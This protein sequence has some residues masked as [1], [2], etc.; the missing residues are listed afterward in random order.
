MVK[1]TRPSRICRERVSVH[2]FTLIELLVVI[3]IIAVLAAMLSPVLDHARNAADLA[4]CRSNL[5]Q[6]GLGL[7]M[8]VQQSG[9]YPGGTTASEIYNAEFLLQPFVAPWP[10]NNY[11]YTGGQTTSYLEPARSVWA[12]PGYNNAHGEFS[13][14]AGSYGYNVTGSCWYAPGPQ[15]GL[16]ARGVPDDTGTG[17]GHAQLIPTRESAVT[18]PSDMIAI[19]DTMFVPQAISPGP[20]DGFID[21]AMPFAVQ[22]TYGWSVYDQVLNGLPA[23]DPAVRALRQRHGARWNVVFCDGHV[24]T[25]RPG[26]PSGLFDIRYAP[27]AGRWNCDGLPHNEGWNPPRGP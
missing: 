7:S 12:C 11:G 10:S 4:A 24:E 13:S 20:L 17:L 3:A 6:I 14:V 21:L 15:Y 25:L 22:G 9:A 27:V 26:G 18:H 5:R 23:S 16:G 8:Y 2:A 1:A 19:A